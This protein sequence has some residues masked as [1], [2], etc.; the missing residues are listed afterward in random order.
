MSTFKNVDK[1]KAEFTDGTI[2]TTR[3]GEDLLNMYH[4]DV[5]DLLTTGKC[6]P[7]A[8]SGYIKAGIKKLESNSLV[9]LNRMVKDTAE[10]FSLDNTDAEF[11]EYRLS[12][13]LFPWQKVV[14]QSPAKR[15]TMACG[16]RS[17][18][19][20]GEAYIAVN[21]CTNG[22]DTINGYKKPRMVAIIGLTVEKC[23]EI[24]WQNVL[25]AAEMSGMKF[26]ADNSKYRVTFANGSSIQ[27]YGNNNKAERE[28]V[29]GTE[30]SLIIIDEAQSQPALRY[31]LE[32][33]FGP[34][35]QGRDST[36]V[37]SGTGSLTGYGTWVDICNDTKWQHFHYTMEDNPSVPAG[38]L[39]NVL[40]ENNWTE[41][42]ITYQREYLANHVIDTTRMIVPNWHT[43]DKVPEDFVC[44]QCY[45][46]LDYGWSDYT[47][48]API[49][50]NNE[51]HGYILKVQKFNH[52]ETN[53]IAN[54][55]KALVEELA[56][57]YKVQPI[58]LADNSH[59]MISATIARLGV[60]IYNAVKHDATTGLRQQIV[61]TSKA[62]QD[63]TLEIVDCPDLIEDFK[64]FVWK[65]DD[66]KKCVIYEED[67]EYYHPDIYHAL[68][69]A[70]N[71]YKAK[72]RK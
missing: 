63:G 55:C 62:I 61:D 26:K 51:G 40:E 47:A 54:R 21:H 69:Y 32:Q 57:E 1:D 28:K 68:R 18:K 41:D 43:V 20:Y 4:R 65:W 29:R 17:G 30:F 67:S 49:V 48:L 71:T 37:L 27:L 72:Y 12:K 36:V 33:I 52:A 22:F 59:Q 3:T 16:R 24:F 8:M 9:T 6:E 2:L 53:D 39:R 38:A 19:S 10:Y 50:F 42:N 25:T 58:V 23:A 44:T 5:F 35:I 56:K 31:L 46:G 66:E 34:I 60:P 11:I 64:N 45:I 70:Y 13:R 15:I 7:N 14:L